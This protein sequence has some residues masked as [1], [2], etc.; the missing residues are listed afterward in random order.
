MTGPADPARSGPVGG[1]H[2]MR[3]ELRELEGGEEAATWAQRAVWGTLEE[4]GAHADQFNLDWVI[5]VPRAPGI[6]LPAVTEAVGWLIARHESLRTLFH[7]DASGRLRQRVLESL[8][9]DLD[10]E[11][12]LPPGAPAG[13]GPVERIAEDRV[14]EAVRAIRTGRYDHGTQVGFRVT[15]LTES[16]RPHTVVLGF[17]HMAADFEGT[18]IAAEDLIGRLGQVGTAQADDLCVEPDPCDD[19]PPQPRQ[20]ARHQASER[21]RAQSRRAIA[22]WTSTLDGAPVMRLS[23]EA[24]DPRRPRFWR[25]SMRSRAVRHAVLE[26]AAAAGVSSTAVLLAAV[27]RQLGLLTGSEAPCLMVMVSNRGRAPFHRLVSPMA[28]EG[29]LAMPTA[30]T[31]FA[32]LA[33]RA[34]RA[35]MQAYRHAQFDKPEL[36]TALA[37]ARHAADP[38]LNL[39]CWFNDL[40]FDKSVPD[41]GGPD[42]AA[43]RASVAATTTEWVAT[44][45]EQGDETLAFHVYDP[46]E[47]IELTLTTDTWVL[48]P[49]RAIRALREIEATL[50]E[51]AC[52]LRRLYEKGDETCRSV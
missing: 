40:R 17:S 46:H 38:G 44:S 35:S 36:L 11:E 25:A 47:A 1:T 50:V 18:A 21:G 34:W 52:D 13:H 39:A 6:D 20:L 51:A 37:A 7:R 3:I 42:V 5:A 26:I 41:T 8:T 32:G 16:G 15:I 45:D 4:L 30:G 31:D 2:R 23:P 27:A 12:L 29:L 49:D 33:A 48:G 22:Y 14:A 24:A 28:I 19:P 43:L 9:F 10:V